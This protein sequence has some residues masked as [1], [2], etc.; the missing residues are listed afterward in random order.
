MLKKGVHFL[1]GIGDLVL[2]NVNQ[3]SLTP[4]S[5]LNIQRVYN[6][7]M[8]YVFSHIL[9]QSREYCNVRSGMFQN[10][11]QSGEYSKC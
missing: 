5:V 9:H 2:L 7:K 4:I 6:S 1:L 11:D 8:M 10:K 3:I